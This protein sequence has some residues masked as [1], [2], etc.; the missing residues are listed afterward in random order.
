MVISALIDL[1]II[2]YLTKLK[3]I[4]DIKVSQFNDAHSEKCNNS[5]VRGHRA[6]FLVNALTLFVNNFSL[7]APTE[8]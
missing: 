2:E 7:E 1:F 4:N 5:K 3:V 6:E 8:Y